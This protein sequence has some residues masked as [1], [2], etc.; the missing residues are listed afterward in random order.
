MRLRL[1]GAAC[2]GTAREAGQTSYRQSVTSDD[3]DV[4]VIGAGVSGLTTALCLAEAGLRVVVAAADPPP[5][6]TSVAAG[7]VWG[8]HLVGMD[9]RVTRWGEVTLERLTALAADPVTGVRLAAG[10]AASASFRDEPFDWLSSPGEA[11]QCGPAEL[12]AGYACGWRI[13]TPVVSMPA[14][15]SYLLAR[16]E[17]AGGTLRQAEFG[18][19]AEAASQ[20]TAPAIVNC[21]G[22]GARRL[23]PDPEV[24]VVRGQAVVVR[25]SGVEDFFIGVGDDPGDVSYYFPHGEVVVLGG[26][27]EPGNWNREPDPVTAERIQRRCAALEPRLKDA[28]VIEHRVGLRPVRPS[29]RLEAEILGGGRRLLHNY[30]HGGAGVTLSWGCAADVAAVVLG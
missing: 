29:V 14:Y 23:V 4:L 16:L 21:A 11:G 20:T 28:L 9:E 5:R 25:N 3:P 26:T 15:L 10:V 24:T 27:E 6:T 18:S 12:P 1:P 17:R 8:P 22:A 2:R 19:L 13:T 7:A 30:G